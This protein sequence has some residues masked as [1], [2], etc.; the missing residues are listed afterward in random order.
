MRHIF[1]CGYLCCAETAEVRDMLIDHHAILR[2][3]E[4]SH[5]I[6]QS[7]TVDEVPHLARG[8]LLFAF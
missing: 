1:F 4:V 6:L 3:I 5:A 2:A 7:L 8:V